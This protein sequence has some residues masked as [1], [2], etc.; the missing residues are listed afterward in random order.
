M[1]EADTIQAESQPSSSLAVGDLSPETKAKGN[2]MA[3]EMRFGLGLIAV[4][5]AVLAGVAY[6]RLR[7]DAQLADKL[8]REHQ[9]AVDEIAKQAPFGPGGSTEKPAPTAPRPGERL[10]QF[11]SRDGENQATAIPSG[12]TAIASPSEPAS[13]ASSMPDTAGRIEEESLPSS[14]P[15]TLFDSEAEAGHS[16]GV[17]APP[18]ASA[19][20]EPEG[21][22]PASAA[23]FAEHPQVAGQGAGPGFVEASPGA[24]SDE[25]SPVVESP[26]D[27]TPREA[28]SP[29]F[30][31]DAANPTESE[32][33]PAEAAIQSSAAGVQPDEPPLRWSG[34]NPTEPPSSAQEQEQLPA[35]FGNREP[36]PMPE[37]GPPATEMPLRQSDAAAAPKSGI[38]DRQSHTYTVGPNESYWLISKR[39]YGTGGYFKA[40]FEHN[41][42]NFP[43]PNQLRAGDV[44]S[45]PAAA[46]LEQT[47]P[48]LCP[49]RVSQTSGGRGDG[50]VIP[51]SGQSSPRGGT[52]AYVVQEGDT[53]FDIAQYELGSA[54][55]WGEIYELNRNL[56]G[57]DYDYLKPGTELVLPSA[58]RAG[59]AVAEAPSSSFRR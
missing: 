4:L 13:P 32:Q 47:Y 53:L 23:P 58:E 12:P 44:I 18:N 8:T 51:A 38:Y 34:T 1:T 40:L 11:E 20:G 55:R 9:R 16:A 19:G 41:R 24:P 30:T 22:N 43:F 57:N 37:S 49:R 25:W 7:H 5:I 50:G 36:E 3:R 27:Q 10:V 54:S 2:R 56:L 42:R 21:A 39:L 28:I 29:P 14:P 45:A 48:Q 46:V 33:A 6:Y 35:A 26:S 52:R 17:A 15:L 59:S 31:P